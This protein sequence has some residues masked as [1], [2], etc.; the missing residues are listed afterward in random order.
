MKFSPSII[1]DL[2]YYVYL[3]FHSITHEVFYVVK[4]KG[5]RVFAN[6]KD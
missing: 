3:Y 1:D 6:L 2:K 5:N 4:G